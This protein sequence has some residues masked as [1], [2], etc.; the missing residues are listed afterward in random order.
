MSIIWSL[1]LRLMGWSAAN[2]FPHQLKKCVIIVAP[3]TSSWD[4]VIGIA[5]RSTLH[6]TDA[7][8]LGK[9]ELFKPPFGFLFRKL[10]G[11]P[12]E[13][14]GHHNLVEQVSAL[15]AQHDR[16]RLVLSPEGTRKKVDRL[17]TGFYHIAK[18]AGVPIVMASLDYAK[19]QVSFSDPFFPTADEAAD[20]RFIH[21]YYAPVVGKNPEQGMSHL[22]PPPVN[23]QT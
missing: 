9:A 1:F 21:Q 16:F 5:F 11:V 3:H 18:K 8:Y 13:R 20:F 15:F 6:I 22:S 23:P 2:G 4:F 7:R 19:K 17:K 12:V 14:T 10:G